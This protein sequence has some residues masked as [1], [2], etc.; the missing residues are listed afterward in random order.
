MKLPQPGTSDNLHYE[1]FLHNPIN[2][3]LRKLPPVIFSKA[4]IARIAVLG[5]KL[6]YANEDSAHGAELWV[7]DGTA[8][9]T[10][11]VRDIFKGSIGSLDTEWSP[12]F[13]GPLAF[14]GKAYFLANDNIHGAELWV[15]DGTP[16]GTKLLKDVVPGVGGITNDVE[17][18]DNVG[19][20]ITANPLIVFPAHGSLW[21]SDGT[22][23]GT[24]SFAFHDGAG[25]TIVTSQG[26][27]A[28]GG[29]AQTF[30]FEGRPT[31]SVKSALYIGNVVAGTAK[32]VRDLNKT[33]DCL[34]VEYDFIYSFTRY[35]G[36]EF[37][38]GTDKTTI[39]GCPDRFFNSELWVTDGTTAGTSRIREIYPGVGGSVYAQFHFRGSDPQLFTVGG[40][41]PPPGSNAA[42]AQLRCP[43]SA[44]VGQIGGLRKGGFLAHRSLARSEDETEIRAGEG[45]GG[46]RSSRTSAGRHGEHFSAEEKIRIVLEGL[47]GEDSI[48]ELCRR[49]GIAQN[50][51]Y[52]W[53]K[54]FLE[55]GKKRLAGDTARAATSDEVKDLRR[56]ATAL[57]EVV[58]DLTLENRLLKKSVTA[59]GEDEA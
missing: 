3:T 18:N 43:P 42:T 5:D 10:K 56:E 24:T 8:A 26:A 7:S 38:S 44:P 15:T 9:G 21:R 23:A 34:G 4:S 46:D 11:L 20:L 19:H 55:A 54:D 50:L 28:S 32:M 22:P 1:L 48:A 25:K 53:S 57:K 59:D 27:R 39:T 31:G 52:R 35:A 6:V 13:D 17:F 33:L 49:E 12:Y 14:R 58:A 30:V 41:R 37:F 47:R 51:Y 36:K 16:T 2:N 45:A 40:D 29:W